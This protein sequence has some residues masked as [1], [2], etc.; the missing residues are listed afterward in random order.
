VTPRVR[1]KDAGL[2]R[3][4]SVFPPRRPQF[5]SERC[6]IIEA[7]AIIDACY[8][9]RLGSRPWCPPRGGGRLKARDRT[10]RF[11]SCTGGSSVARGCVPTAPRA[12]L[13]RSAQPLRPNCRPAPPRSRPAAAMANSLGGW[14]LLVHIFLPIPLVSMQRALRR[15]QGQTGGAHR[16]VRRQRS[17]GPAATER[18]RSGPARTRARPAPAARPPAHPSL[19]LAPA[20]AAPRRLPGARDPAGHPLP[21]QR[22]QGPPPVHP[23]DPELH[24][25]CAHAR[26]RRR[27]CGGDAAPAAAAAA[28][29]AAAQRLLGASARPSG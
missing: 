8:R 6:V 27:R 12:A 7:G 11:S 5:E 23:Q 14:R 18:H 21:A 4:R 15:G 10:E 20:P 29:A 24:H 16:A 3:L 26:R 28:A 13:R 19:P 2:H 9:W 1:C 17:R 22:A 25:G